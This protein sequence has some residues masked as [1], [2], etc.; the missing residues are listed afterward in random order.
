[1][2]VAGLAYTLQTGDTAR[3]GG[4]RRSAVAPAPD[5]RTLP[6]ML[7]RQA[8]LYGDRRLVEIRGKTWSF[9]E[10]LDVAARF[11]GALRAAGI[12]R[13]DHVA[14]MCGNRQELLQVYL[15]CG[16]IGAVTAPINIRHAVRSLHM[17]W[18][19]PRRSCWCSRPNSRTRS[20]HWT[21]PCHRWARSG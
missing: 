12:E 17:S 13:G 4:H 7:R 6:R 18:R 19:I 10:T 5:E 14:V 16:W 21:S 20:A 15:G 1:M 11:G 3:H 2:F 9:A 8:A